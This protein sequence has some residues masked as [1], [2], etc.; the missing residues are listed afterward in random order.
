MYIDILEIESVRARIVCLLLSFSHNCLSWSYWYRIK[1]V[2]FCCG[3]CGRN[4]NLVK[5]WDLPIRYVDVS[6]LKFSYFHFIFNTDWLCFASL[7]VLVR[8]FCF[9]FWVVLGVFVVF[10][11]WFAEFI[12]THCNFPNILCYDCSYDISVS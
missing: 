3:Y 2:S 6:I 7:F 4:K 9:W 11:F 10:F 8:V 1:V 5:M 12:L